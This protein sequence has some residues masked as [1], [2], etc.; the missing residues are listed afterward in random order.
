MIAPTES[1]ESLDLSRKKLAPEVFALWQEHKATGMLPTS[2][3]FLYYE[4]VG[5]GVVSKVQR[6]DT[7]RR[8][9]MDP[10][11]AL[12]WLREKELIPW[13]DIVDETRS[14]EN[15]CPAGNSILEGVLSGLDSV[16]TDLWKGTAPLILTESRSLAGVLRSLASGYRCRIASTNGQTNAFL[17]NDVAWRI[18]TN[19]PVL[20]F[21]DWDKSGGDIEANT[22][23]I[24]ESLVGSLEWR[25][26]AL[27]EAQVEKYKLSVIPKWDG[28]DRKYHDAVETEAL[29]QAVIVGILLTR[30]EL[31]LPQPL[32]VLEQ[33]ER[34]QRAEIRRRLERNGKRKRI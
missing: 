26:L 15:Y 11:S 4:L 12:L 18:T 9:D 27:T 32:D 28:R 10:A 20:Y 25:R 17:R 19:N 33:R 1:G 6:E 30:L 34:R 8:P 13:S 23:R 2:A 3:R 7:T 24:L 16:R 29:S 5:K 31:R 22:R 14:V 21:G